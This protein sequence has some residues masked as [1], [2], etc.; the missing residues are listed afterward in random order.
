[1]IPQLADDLLSD[2]TYNN[3]PSYTYEMDKNKENVN[4]HC[5]GVKAVE[6]AIFKILNTERYQ[7]AIY[8]WN[9]GVELAELIG[10]P[11]SFCLPEIERRIT[12]ALMQDDR[13]SSVSNFTF[14]FPKKGVILTCF[15]VQSTEGNLTVKKEV[16]V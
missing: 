3:Q 2:V 12:E 16:S 13:I 1:M 5:Q 8:S 7:S 14:S 11:T 6:Q 9:Y 15:D 10:K 4:G